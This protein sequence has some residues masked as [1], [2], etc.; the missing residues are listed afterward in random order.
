MCQCTHIKKYI[1]RNDC[2]FFNCCLSN[3][4][5]VIFQPRLHIYRD[6]F[7]R[8][9]KR[10]YIKWMLSTL[11]STKCSICCQKMVLNLIFVCVSHISIILF[12]STRKIG[13]TD[14][15][16]R[17]KETKIIERGG[18]IIHIHTGISYNIVHDR[19]V[20]LSKNDM[21]GLCLLFPTSLHPLETFFL[22]FKCET[23]KNENCCLLARRNHHRCFSWLLLWK[24]QNCLFNKIC[25]A[26]NWII[27]HLTFQFNEDAK[28]LNYSKGGDWNIWMG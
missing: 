17:R 27:L 25:L 26:R 1:Y 5:I 21:Q 2:A 6:F 8:R 4:S 3:P 14:A 16:V 28:L 7:S 9:T 15:I 10:Q 18:G 13:H 23:E 11:T 20:S 24:I 19:F 12:T 22:R